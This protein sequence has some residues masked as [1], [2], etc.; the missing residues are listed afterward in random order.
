MSASGSQE[1]E[2]KERPNRQSEFL[3]KI[4]ASLSGYGKM[5]PLHMSGKH[6]KPGD[7]P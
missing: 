7:E 2:K 6:E 5:Y 1:E 3:H 4:D